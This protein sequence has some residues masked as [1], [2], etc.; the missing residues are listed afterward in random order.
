MHL[1]YRMRFDGRLVGS[2]KRSAA[3]HRIQSALLS[4]TPPERWTMEF[5]WVE[6]EGD[7]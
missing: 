2:W 3:K 7:S 4:M 6:E 5:R 1:E